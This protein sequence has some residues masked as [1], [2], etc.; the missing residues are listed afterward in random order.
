MEQI[1]PNKGKKSSVQIP[2]GADFC[3]KVKLL[4][5]YSAIKLKLIVKKM[6]KTRCQGVAPLPLPVDSCTWKVSN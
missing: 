1:R 4:F 5:Q 3:Y 2:D 6:P